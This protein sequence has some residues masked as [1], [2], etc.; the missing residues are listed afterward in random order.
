MA[1]LGHMVDCWDRTETQ[2]RSTLHSHNLCWLKMTKPH[3]HWGTSGPVHRALSITESKQRPLEQ[4]ILHLAVEGVQESTVHQHFEIARIS[5]E[6]PR[7]DVSGE[8]AQRNLV[9]LLVWPGRHIPR[10]IQSQCTPACSIKTNP[11]VKCSFRVNRGY[12]S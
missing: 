8:N 4:G 6:M 2:Q 9:E 5:A 1:T 7:T 3:R 10:G 11:F 12:N